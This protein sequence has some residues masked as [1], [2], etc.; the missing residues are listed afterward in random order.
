[1]LPISYCLGGLTLLPYKIDYNL[2]RTNNNYFRPI[3]CFSKKINFVWGNHLFCRFQLS[4]EN[5]ESANKNSIKDLKVL[6]SQQIRKHYKTLDTSLIYSPMSPPCLNFVH[7]GILIK[8]L[9]NQNL[10]YTGE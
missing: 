1:M 3:A 2:P 8:L 9:Y 6:F 7:V 4:D 5:F 10:R